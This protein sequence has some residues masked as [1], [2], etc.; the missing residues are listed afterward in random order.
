MDGNQVSQELV[1]KVGEDFESILE[2]TNKIRQKHSEDMSVFRAI[3]M[4]FE[5]RPDLRVTKIAR[6]YNGV[7]VTV[8][9][10]RTFTAD[11]AIVT[12]PLGVLKSNYIKFEPRLPEWKEAAI[13]DL[14]VGI[15]NKIILHFEKLTDKFGEPFELLGCKER[16]NATSPPLLTCGSQQVT[17]PSED[18]KH[19]PLSKN[20]PIKDGNVTRVG[21]YGMPGVGKTTMM[22]QVRNAMVEKKEFEEVAFAVVS[23]TWDVKSIQ[24]RLASDLRLYDLAKE[25]DE[26]VRACLLRRRLKN[27]KKILVILDDVW[28][29][30]TLEDMGL[31]FGDSRG[32]KI[33][34]TSRKG[35]VCEANKCLPFLIHVLSNEEARV[36]FRQHAG[37]CIEDAGINPVAMAV[38]NECGG[39]PLI[40]RA[41]GEALKDGELC[42]WKDAR[43]QFKNFTPR[44]IVNLDEQVYKTLE[45]SFNKLNPEEAKSCL[46]LC[47]L[48]PEDAEISIDDLSL[49][50]MAM[51][52]LR[53]MDSIEDARNRV[54]SLVKALKTSCLLLGC[55]DGDKVKLHDVIRDVAINIASE[56]VKYRFKVKPP[57]SVWPAMDEACRAITLRIENIRELRRKLECPQL[58][59]LMLNCSWDSGTKIPGTFLDGLEKLK[60]LILANA[61]TYWILDS[62]GDGLNAREQHVRLLSRMSMLEIDG[63]PKLQS[64]WNGDPLG[65]LDLRSLTEIKIENCG[66]LKMLFSCS[67]ARALEQLRQ[68]TVACCPMLETIVYDDE[69]KEGTGDDIEFPQLKFLHLKN[70][71]MLSSFCNAKVALTMYSLKA[72]RL[73]NCPQ[74]LRFSSGGLHLP[75]MTILSSPAGLSHVADLKEHLEA[76]AMKINDSDFDDKEL[77]TDGGCDGEGLAMDKDSDGEMDFSLVEGLTLDGEDEIEETGILGYGPENKEKMCTNEISSNKK[78]EKD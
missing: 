73:Q 32:C 3:S 39:L 43:Q 2:E 78:K 49:L 58:E 65:I 37:N 61:N 54:L 25:D 20:N 76:S 23:A 1:S 62:N 33:L 48:F 68:L 22:E 16:L 50:A 19:Y 31:D 34:M 59:T 56:D 29:K 40:I 70:L 46:L 12:V 35:W 57:I 17:C 15:E 6:R 63:L 77:A 45:L 36:L 10:G 67:V 7:K 53:S 72:A 4:V 44:N 38:L 26:S 55:E 8:E 14:G 51:G 41:V 18:G 74:M 21:I 13:T 9:S 60:V 75:K 28:D 5:R 27:G 47:S 71:P 24:G 42:E 64:L 30:L 52:F 69:G 11:A 66:L